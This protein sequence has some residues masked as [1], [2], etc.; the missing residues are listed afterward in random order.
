[1]E[2]SQNQNA[3]TPAA[4]NKPTGAPRQAITGLTPPQLGEAMIR[5]VRPTVVA[6]SAAAS[7]LGEKLIRS[8]ILAPLGWLLLAPLYFKRI[9]PGICKRYTLTNQSL[10][11]QKGLKP[12][13]TRIIALSDIEEVRLDPAS[14]N[15]FYRSGTLE[16]MGKGTV[17]MRLTGVPEPDSFRNA[18]LNACAAWVPGKGKLLTAWEPAKAPGKS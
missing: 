8:I 10:K 13:P 16:I 12:S 14:Y 3:V 11:I 1:M 5:E 2:T 15:Q 6:A 9:M 4:N 17:Q 18:I 7:A